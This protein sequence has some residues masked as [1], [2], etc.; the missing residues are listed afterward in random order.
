MST[1]IV[2]PWLHKNAKNFKKW[3]VSSHLNPQ[4][5]QSCHHSSTLFLQCSVTQLL[6]PFL[7]K[8]PKKTPTNKICHQSLTWFFLPKALLAFFFQC[9]EPAFTYWLLFPHKVASQNCQENINLHNLS[10]MFHASA[11]FRSSVYSLLFVS[12]RWVYFSAI[13]CD[14]ESLSLSIFSYLFDTKQCLDVNDSCL[15]TFFSVG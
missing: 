8:E 15:K 2:C 14:C 9:Q 10:C 12:F 6:C 5:V 3:T 11:C 4:I 1:G 13:F 7:K